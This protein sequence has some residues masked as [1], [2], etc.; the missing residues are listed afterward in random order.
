MSIQITTALLTMLLAS[1][2][3]P[4]SA[5][6]TPAT[7]PKLKG[8]GDRTVEVS[9][10]FSGSPTKGRLNGG[11]NGC[12]TIGM[13]VHGTLL[14][15]LVDSGSSDTVV[16]FKGLNNY[17]GPAI[18]IDRPPKAPI[19]SGGY[20][21]GSGFTGF[22]ADT[23]VSLPG[24]SLTSDAAPIV[25]MFE[26]TVDNIFISGNDS[27]G[28][29]G[30]GYPGIAQYKSK[31]G[32]VMDAWVKTGAVK[33]D[34]IA[35][36]GCPY[37]FA[38]ESYIDF[39]NSE[40]ATDCNSSPSTT[41]W[42]TSGT[43]SF[44]T[45]DVRGVNIGSKPVKLPKNWQSGFSNSGISV[46]DS[47]TSLILGNPAVVDVLQ[48]AVESSGGLPKSLT[49]AEIKS[50]FN[51]N[52]TIPEKLNIDWAALPTI[53]FDILADKKSSGSPSSAAKSTIRVELGPHQYMQADEKGEINFLMY[54]L[55]NVTGMLF[56]VPMHTHLNIVL[57]RSAGRVGF[58]QGCGCDRAT[59][60]YP[61]LT[62]VDGTVFSAAGSSSPKPSNVPATT[63]DGPSTTDSPATTVD[64]PSTTDDIPSASLGSPSTTDSPATT[65][66]GPS[67]TAD[68]PSTTDSPATTVDGPSTTADSP[69]TTDSPATTVDGPSTT[70]DSPSTTDSPATTVDGP[71]TTADSPSTT[72]SPATTVDGP[73]TTADSPSTTD[74]PATTVDGPSTTADSP[75][76]TDS[77][78]TTTGSP[79]TTQTTRASRSTRATSRGPKPTSGCTRM[80]ICCIYI[81]K[82]CDQD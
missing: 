65:V 46:I 7:M 31:Y 1:A 27:Q 66:D 34:Q 15:L 78:A 28:L 14:N 47:C 53:S 49:P 26:Q 19:V 42:A 11:F 3:D 21:D 12:F 67:T 44:Y 4:V 6:R 57:D 13:D 70:A 55:D 43:D 36:H 18:D 38:K 45:V 81:G 32:T 64:G 8:F 68:S 2:Y 9:N 77:P 39:G 56:G 54:G 37:S 60:G 52:Y 73:S 76:T 50:F 5:A 10:S 63:V 72:D 30:V 58:S 20:M 74:S 23:T 25:A 35:F 22:G 24:T 29:M 69:S 82:S 40:P 33:Q 62:S 61:K 59:D 80:D 17:K 51:L 79:S 41:V 75:S 48:K 71:S 16:P